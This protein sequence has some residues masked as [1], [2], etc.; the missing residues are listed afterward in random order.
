[1]RSLLSPHFYPPPSFLP[2]LSASGLTLT[3]VTFIGEGEQVEV[4]GW[5]CSFPRDAS[6]LEPSTNKES[7]SECGEP[8]ED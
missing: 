2:H 3:F 4:D 6:R 5:D 1:M 8:A 7:L